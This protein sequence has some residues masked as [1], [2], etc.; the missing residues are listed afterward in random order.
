[1]MFTEIQP[2][3]VRGRSLKDLI[4]HWTLR[5]SFMSLESSSSFIMWRQVVLHDHM[6]PHVDEVTDV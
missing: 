1:M 5:L 2:N 6:L 4:R 3:N